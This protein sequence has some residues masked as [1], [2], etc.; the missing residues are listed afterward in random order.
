MATEQTNAVRVHTFGGSDVL[1]HEEVPRPEPTDD[2]LLARVHAAGVNPVDWMIREGYTDEALDPTLPWIPGWDFSGV[3]EATGSNVS[4]FDAGD[5]VFGMVRM[6]D[7]GE[8]Y[9]EYTAVPA[10]EVVEKP[11]SLSHTEAAAVPMVSLTAWRALFEKGE[12]GDGDRVLIHAAA[13]GVGHMAVQL[14]AD[15]GAHVI[16]T[17]SGRNEEYLRR[18]GVDEFVNY[19]EQRFEAV[20]DPVDVVL[21]AVGDDT[22]ERSIDVLRDGAILVT[23]PVPPSDEIVETAAEQ[24]DA[25][26]R[27]FSVE[28]DATTLTEIVEK[29]DSGTIEPTI[30]STYPLTEAAAAHEESENGHVRGKLVLEL[31]GHSDNNSR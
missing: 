14:A 3:V 30:N 15:A 7:P 20:V 12:L 18:L 19:R 8:T 1:T 27:W 22:L 24:H 28:P 31:N 17:A 25:D 10:D 5:E 16:G 4:A 11:A 9:A 13:G 2:E 23:L 6:P 29:I 26:V 21:D